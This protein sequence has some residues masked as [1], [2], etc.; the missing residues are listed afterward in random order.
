[1]MTARGREEDDLAVLEHGSDAC[2]REG[3]LCAA[4]NGPIDPQ[5]MSGK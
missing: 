1:M 3:E 2:S 4:R 5:V